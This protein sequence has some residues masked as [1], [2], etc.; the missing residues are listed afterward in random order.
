MEKIR[1]DQQREI[2]PLHPPKKAW[3]DQCHT[4]S[5]LVSSSEDGKASGK[6]L[7]WGS[8]VVCLL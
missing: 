2:S 7:V 4:H 6:I 5:S 1:E 8:E 3:K